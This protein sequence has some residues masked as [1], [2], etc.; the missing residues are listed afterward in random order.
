MPGWV[1]WLAGCLCSAR[2]LA[3]C[4]LLAPP[5]PSSP[6]AAAAPPRRSSRGTPWWWMGRSGCASGWPPHAC[7]LGQPCLPPAALPAPSL[8][9]SLAWPAQHLGGWRRRPCRPLPQAM[10]ARCAPALVVQAA[11]GAPCDGHS[12]EPRRGGQESCSGAGRRRRR[13]RRRRRCA[14]EQA[15]SRNATACTCLLPVPALACCCSPI[16]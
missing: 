6:A 14:Q 2:T 4:L 1:C 8:A 10:T 3:S 16:W 12:G 5:C 15:V 11:A 13:R 7:C 9:V